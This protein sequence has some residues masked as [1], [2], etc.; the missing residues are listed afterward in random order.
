[1]RVALISLIVAF[2]SPAL[3]AEEQPTLGPK[4]FETLRSKDGKV[5]LEFRGSGRAD[6]I[7]EP[8]QAWV[9]SAA[10]KRRFLAMPETYILGGGISVD[11]RYIALSYHVSSGGYG[12]AFVRTPKGGY[13]EFVDNGY[14]M[15]Q[16]EAGKV[17]GVRFR[18]IPQTPGRN[19]HCGIY[20]AH[21]PDRLLFPIGNEF[22]FTY[23]L[24][25]RRITGWER[26]LLEYSRSDDESGISLSLRQLS[27]NRGVALV[28]H[29]TKKTD[30][31]Q[32]MLV[33]FPAERI[34]PQ[35]VKKFSVKRTFAKT[36]VVT[37][38]ARQVTE[39]SES[40]SA[41]WKVDL[42]GS[43]VQFSSL[44]SKL[45]T[46]RK[47][48]SPDAEASVDWPAPGQFFLSRP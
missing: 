44:L 17:P 27:G 9:I 30:E 45:S 13:R 39:G 20:L 2:V 4:V 29:E 25:D 19:I 18:D 7:G 42:S 28:L 48:K 43:G 16:V 1:M 24:E 3:L 47:W 35:K 15:A 38:N 21:S 5:A 46:Y 11:G 26:L 23:S 22:E 33:S 36:D 34:D 8:T 41:R 31:R 12:A 6:D 32:E 14:A 10:G 37:L 40:E